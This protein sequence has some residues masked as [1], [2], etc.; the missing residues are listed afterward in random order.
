MAPISTRSIVATWS[1]AG[2]VHL[3]DITKHSLLLD[4]PSVGGASAT[5][6]KG[7]KETPLFSFVGH[8]VSYIISIAISQK[9]PYKYK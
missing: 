2:K 5:A 8:Q 4:S 6:I 1:E 7:H 9:C 3:W